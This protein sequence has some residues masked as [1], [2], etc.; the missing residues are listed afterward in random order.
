[1]KTTLTA[2]VL[3]S[4][5][6]GSCGR[7]IFNYLQTNVPPFIRLPTKIPHQSSAGALL[8]AEYVYTALELDAW[9][10]SIYR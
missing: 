2:L 10:F 1:M 7:G 4:E 6:A 9:T 8:T 5:A 3:G